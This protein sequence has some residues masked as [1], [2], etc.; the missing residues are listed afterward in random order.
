MYDPRWDDPRERDD[1]RAPVP[2]ALTP[3]GVRGQAFVSTASTPEAAAGRL[4][5][6]ASLKS[7]CDERRALERRL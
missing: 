6:P 7:S 5:I 1:G 3:P 4:R 2:V